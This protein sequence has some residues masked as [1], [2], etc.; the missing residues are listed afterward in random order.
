MIALRR[1]A[2]RA[3]MEEFRHRRVQKEYI[4]LVDGIVVQ[5]QGVIS[6]P[7]SRCV[8]LPPRSIVDWEKG[9]QAHTEYKVLDHQEGF[10]RIRLFPKTGRSHQLRIHMKYIGH[11]I[12]GDRFYFSDSKADRLMLHAQTIEYTHPYHKDVMRCSSKSPF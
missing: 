5:E 12:L 1:K 2:E 4:A 11:P 3:L 9:K 8:G 10:S 7:L 6:V